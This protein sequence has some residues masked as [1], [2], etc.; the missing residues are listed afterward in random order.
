M[1]FSS[2]AIA[3]GTEDVEVINS[4]NEEDDDDEEV[5]VL[6]TRLRQIEDAKK[7][8]DDEGTSTGSGL[9]T[10]EA[11]WRAEC[12]QLLQRVAAL[13]PTMAAEITECFKRGSA[14]GFLF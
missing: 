11:A 1:K 7:G 12:E 8:S 10:S 13:D 6:R 2:E 4:G 5:F 9:N 14:A 3:A